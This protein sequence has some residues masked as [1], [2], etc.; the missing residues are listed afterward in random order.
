MIQIRDIHGN[1]IREI[2]S[3]DL[4]WFK[5]DGMDLH[6]ADLRGADLSY[7]TFW[8]ANLEGADLRGANL[9]EAYLTDEQ[10]WSIIWDEKTRFKD[11]S[12]KHPCWM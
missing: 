1:L 11:D 2:D 9:S 5:F 8:G 4:T 10:R 6:E 3:E 12:Y 7:S